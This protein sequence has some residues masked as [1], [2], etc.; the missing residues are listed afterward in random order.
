MPLHQLVMLSRSGNHPIVSHCLSRAT[1]IVSVANQIANSQMSPSRSTLKALGPRFRFQ[2]P[3]TLNRLVGA[4]N[5]RRLRERFVYMFARYR[6]RIGSG[7]VGERH[8]VLVYRDHD[9]EATSVAKPINSCFIERLAL[10][11]V[12]R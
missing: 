2:F 9:M 8:A 7:S 6:K 5:R 1:I 3:E 4:A 10:L 12:L 11:E